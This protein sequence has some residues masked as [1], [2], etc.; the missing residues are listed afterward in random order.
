MIGPTAGVSGTELIGFGLGGAAVL[1]MAWDWWANR[2]LAA[3]QAAA[4]EA[5]ASGKTGLIGAL[6]DRIRAN[7]ERQNAQEARIRELVTRLDEEINLRHQAQEEN[8]RLRLRV[9]ELEFAIRQLGGNVP[10]SA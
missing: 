1:K 6:E 7:E 5:D 10:T 2:R 9:T 8:L 3:A 4:T